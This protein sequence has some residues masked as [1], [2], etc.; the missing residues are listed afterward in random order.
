M[1]HGCE[2]KLGLK[3]SDL[4][5][6]A[7][8]EGDQRPKSQSHKNLRGTDSSNSEEFATRIINMT[9]RWAKTNLT[10][11]WAEKRVDKQKDK[12]KAQK[13]IKDEIK[14]KMVSYYIR[15]HKDSKE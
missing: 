11:A 2:A 4:S 3:V 15:E 7:P 10:I 13:I 8:D 9:K 12:T 5:V 14:R 6:A 1:K